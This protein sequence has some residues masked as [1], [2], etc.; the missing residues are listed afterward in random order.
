MTHLASDPRTST[1]DEDIRARRAAARSSYALMA[2][3]VGTAATTYLF[4]IVVARSDGAAAVGA[5]SAQIATITFLGGAASLNLTN[6]LARFL[7]V[8][9]ARATRLVVGSYLAAGGAAAI[10][11]VAFLA[12]P[13]GPAATSQ[14]IGATGFVVLVVLSALF[15]I[16]DGGLIGLG[17]A[18]WVPVENVTMGFA[19]LALLPVCAA[20][21]AAPGDAVL[22]WGAAMGLAVVVLNVI[23]LGRL[24]PAGRGAAQLPEGRRL[25][26]FVAVGAVN[27][28]VATTVTVFLPAIVT[29]SMGERLGGYFY[30]PWMVISIATLLLSNVLIS[31]VRESVAEPAAAPAILTGQL[32]LGAALVGLGVV[33]CALVPRLPLA[34]LGDDF[35]DEASGLLRGLG[36]ALP[37]TAVLLLFW[38][39]CLIQQRPWPALVVNAV[40][41]VATVGTV[42]TFGDVWGLTGVGAAI[43]AIQ[44]L[45]AVAVLP[46]TLRWLAALLEPTPATSSAEPSAEASTIG[47]GGAHAD[48]SRHPRRPVPEPG[49]RV[50]ATALLAAVAVTTGLIVADRGGPLAVAAT[51]VVSLLGPGLGLVVGLGPR[52]GP[53]RAVTTLLVS[54]CW[55][56]T[57][58]LLCAWT[59]FQQ[60]V[61]QYVV[62]VAPAVVGAGAA[63]RRSE[64]WVTRGSTGENGSWG[65]RFR[66][67]PAAGVLLLVASAV[68]WVTAVA[69]SRDRP[70]DEYGLLPGLGPWF[71]VAVALAVAAVVL[72]LLVRPASRAL[73]A[74]GLVAVGAMATPPR[75]VFDHNLLAGWA[76]KHLGAVDLIVRQDPLQDPYDVFQQWPGFFA[77]GAQIEVLSG[78]DALTYAN[79]AQPLVVALA[80]GGLF[81]TARQLYGGSLVPALATLLFLSTMWAGQ[82]YYSPQS[83]AFALTSLALVHVVT[84][85]QTLPQDRLQAGW[86]ARRCGAVLRGLP[87]ARSSPEGRGV[88]VGTAVATYLVV[89]VSHPLTPFVLVL[90]LAPLVLLGWVSGR[91]RWGCVGLALLPFLWLSLH[92]EVL[93]TTSALN[94]FSLTNAQGL[95]TGPTSEAQE[96]AALCA[97]AVAMLV[98]GGG[99][100]AALTYFRRFGTVVVPVMLGVMPLFVLL[101]G[102]YG[103]EA[104]Y[105]V[106]LF[107]SPWFCAVL[108]KRIGDLVRFRTPVVIATAVLSAAAF[109]ASAQASAFG[110]YPFLVV[111]DDQVSASRWLAEE[112][113]PGSTVVHLTHMFPGRVS[114]GY[115]A[116]NPLH[117]IND[118]VVIGYPQFER[119]RLLTMSAPELH[120]G[121]TGEFGDGLHLVLA[122]SME[123]ETRY[124]G[125]LPEGAVVDLASELAASPYWTVAYANDDV[126]VFTPR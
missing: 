23:L 112:T 73:A 33:G 4:W 10:A 122:R 41:A 39:I 30:V 69:G 92:R 104:P 7:P 62:V 64:G 67:G 37:G 97:R 43:C 124:Y 85:L 109:L 57:V 46:T 114:A 118:P 15:L 102:S 3:A 101:G 117:T 58:A 18:S 90:Q 86:F 65:P 47:H 96:L 95:I 89:I 116:R 61:V 42:A 56:S 68:A 84:L 72:A 19:R 81:A 13:W 31:A 1:T 106:W 80:A 12:T 70:V 21:L 76:Y 38:A 45:A 44:T 17:K 59:T 108:A 103:G 120:A 8:A 25:R 87:P 98:L 2:S 11:A 82:F 52:A 75:I 27:T 48:R 93:D 36:L 26:T 94:G 110:M 100:L 50:A 16:Q 9:G 32:R 88:L 83:F 6:V 28:A 77:L 35:A 91:W 115:A 63:L 99:L 51:V 5:A 125:V 20:L 24:A 40:V 71:A 60:P 14:G 74:A 119:D 126:W 54:I 53:H 22:A 78:S 123:R 66:G 79:F 121:L 55:S 113:P 111:S 107:A 34:L 29:F 49:A 105:R